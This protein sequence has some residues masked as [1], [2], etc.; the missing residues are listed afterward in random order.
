[1]T[2]GFQTAAVHE[3]VSWI[4][5]LLCTACTLRQVKSLDTNTS[6]RRHAWDKRPIVYIAGLFPLSPAGVSPTGEVYH[7]T[8]QGILPSAILAQDHVNQDR[9]I[10]KDYQ[11]KLLANDSK[12]S[13]WI[14]VGLL[15]KK[16]EVGVLQHL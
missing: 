11:L 15:L 7:V 12:V 6:P 3:Y 9:H 2:K 14:D 8:G 5:L 16:K 10:L 1:M 13:G 4:L